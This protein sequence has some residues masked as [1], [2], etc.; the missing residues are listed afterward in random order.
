MSVQFH[1]WRCLL[2]LGLI[3]SP[4][5]SARQ[6]FPSDLETQPIR[7]TGTIVLVFTP[8]QDAAGLI[9]D[10]INQARRQILV[11]SYTFTHKTIA[12]A[13]INAQQR[14]VQVRII[15]DK[16][17]NNLVKYSQ[18]PGL[19][20]AGV[21]V[22]LD[23]EHLAAHNKVMVIDAESSEAV[24]ITGSFNFTGAAQYRNA[25]NLMLIRGNPLLTKRFQTNWQNHLQH[26]RPF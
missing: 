21:A 4:L 2:L 24:V 25:E 20:T 17:Q 23:G 7:A 3:A 12:R 19:A 26:S 15:A 6:S 22:W 5:V 18:I 14:G 13:L 9:I 11:Q 8:E 10:A 1:L 16:E